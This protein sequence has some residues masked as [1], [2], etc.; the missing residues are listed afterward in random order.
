[1]ASKKA[2]E[3][4]AGAWCTK[5]TSGTTMD[6]TLAEVFADILDEYID[7]LIWM[8]GGLPQEAEKEWARIRDKLVI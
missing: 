6:P 8:S 2:I 4:A 3:R 1:M 7:A 5:K